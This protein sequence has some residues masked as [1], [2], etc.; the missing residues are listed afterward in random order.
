MRKN[1]NI[2]SPKVLERYRTFGL[3]KEGL[4]TLSEASK[5]LNLSYRHTHRLF[6]RLIQAGMNPDSLLHKRDHPSWNRLSEEERE[7]VIEVFDS[8]PEINNC[9]LSDVL[10]ETSGRSLSPSTI[11]SILMES[12]RYHPQRKKRRARKRFERKSFG[13]LVQMDTSE[14][15]WLPA[16]GK[17]TYLVAMEDDYSRE[18]LAARIFTS[19]T[20]WNNLC[21]IREMVERYGVFQALYTDNNSMFKFIRRGFSMHFEYRS[22]LEKIQ[23]QIN[24]AL[25]ELGILLIHHEPF[26]PQCKGKIERL[27]AF[28]QDR[29][30]YPLKDI[31]DL[32]EANGILDE[33]REWYN[34]KRIHSITG[35]RPSDRHHPSSFEP[36]PKG[37][38][39]DDVFCFKDTRVIKK[40]NTFNYRGRVYQITNQIY[41]FSWNKAKITLHILPE[42]C[43]RAFYQGKFIQEF[44]YKI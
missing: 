28:M 13:E 1:R 35:L 31:K 11:R 4:L 24:R 26:Q 25:L 14:H 33:W 44:P 2:Y 43:I 10:E 41:R 34:K 23:T 32:S 20:S 40:D 29:L 5:K 6:H 12:G 18:F 7:K 37:V 17:R 42:K 36:L 15:L 16:L 30:R 22:D 3:V 8:Y 9:H 19:D 39:L 27:F 38:N 21:V